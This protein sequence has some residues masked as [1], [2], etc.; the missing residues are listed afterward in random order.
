MICVS[1]KWRLFAYSYDFSLSPSLSQLPF[2][3]AK[4]DYVW[5]K[6]QIDDVVSAP[7]TALRPLLT[8]ARPIEMLM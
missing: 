1:S 2:L 5:G 6:L 7:P 8:S 4:H 3:D